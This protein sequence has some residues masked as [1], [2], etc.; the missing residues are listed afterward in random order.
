MNENERYIRQVSLKE[1]GEKGQNKLASSKILIVGIGGLGC[2]A[3]L[4]LAAAGA[5]CIG[6]ADDDFVSLNNLQRQVLFSTKDVGKSKVIVAKEKIKD[7][8]DG[9][10]IICY[11]E[12]LTHKNALDIIKGYDV[13]IDGTD[14]FPSKYLINDACVLLDKP[15]VYGSVSKF[16]G[17]VAV[18]NVADRNNVKCNYR[19]LFPQ[20]PDEKILNCAEEGVLGLTTGIIGMMQANE[21]VKLL[22]GMGEPL[23]NQLLIFNSLNNQSYTLEIFENREAYQLPCNRDEFMRTDYDWL[24]ATITDIEE[25]DGTQLRE[26]LAENETLFIDVR[27]IEEKPEVDFKH[28]RMPLSDFKNQIENIGADRIVCICQ[29]GKRSIDAARILMEKFGKSKKIY[30]LKGGVLSLQ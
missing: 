11:D 30:S 18:F 8:N 16:E 3:L 13:V 6:I 22:T 19:D 24:C 26:M 14:N 20:P 15:L 7:I 29:T 1:F 2:P 23:V 21:A 5:G 17:Q 10:E 25:I 4:Y 28:E 9:I 12:K 27:E